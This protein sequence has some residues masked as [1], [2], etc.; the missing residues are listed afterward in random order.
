MDATINGVNNSSYEWAGL[1]PLGDATIVLKGT[2]T[3]KG[4]YEDYPGILAPE[5]YTLTIKGTGSFTASPSYE[6]QDDLERSGVAGIGGVHYTQ[7]SGNIV[8]E[9][10]ISLPLAVKKVPV[11][12]APLKQNAVTSPSVAEPSMPRV[13]IRQP[14]SEVA[15][16]ATAAPSPSRVAM[17]LLRAVSML[18]LSEAATKAIAA[19]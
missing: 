10:A 11:L 15:I 9:A 2:N 6:S 13:A 8:I 18:P 7:H 1:T 5:N 4:F 16:K 19:R 14:V 12:E 17:L 3:V